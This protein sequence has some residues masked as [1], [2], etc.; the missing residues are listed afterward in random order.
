MYT[1]CCDNLWKGLIMALKKNLE[2]SGNFFSYFVATPYDFDPRTWPIYIWNH[3]VQNL[4]FTYMHTQPSATLT[5]KLV[6]NDRKKT[7]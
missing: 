6:G 1:F 3:F 4:F 5:F 2:N 7:R